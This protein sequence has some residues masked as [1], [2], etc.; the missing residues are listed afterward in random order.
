MSGAWLVRK[1]DIGESDFLVSQHG[2]DPS[3]ADFLIET[4]ADGCMSHE[5]FRDRLKSLG[6][7][8]DSRKAS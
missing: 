1:R 4:V 3:D 5:E 6:I 7:L 2:Y 8:K